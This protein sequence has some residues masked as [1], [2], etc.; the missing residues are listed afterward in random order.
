RRLLNARLADVAGGPGH[1]TV[2][3]EQAGQAQAYPCGAVILALGAQPW[4]LGAEHWVDRARTRTQAE[5]AAELAAGGLADLR[6]IVIQLCAER[7]TAARC[8]RVCC[9]AGL[10]QALQA[11]RL[12]PAA[13]VTVLYRDLFLGGPAGDAAWDEL[14]EA[15]A[16]G[17]AFIRYHPAHPPV[18]GEKALMVPIP[19]TH[20]AVE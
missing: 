16:A 18:V 12:Q 13:E 5:F 4:P 3:I 9:R 19:A 1:Y 6:H 17:V 20:D 14:V 10:R 11:K 8:S 15:Q 7:E 2:T